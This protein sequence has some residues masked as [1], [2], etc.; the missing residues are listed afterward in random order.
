MNELQIPSKKWGFALVCPQCGFNYVHIRNAVV[1]AGGD[2][3]A[4]TPHG[5]M[6][7]PDEPAGRGTLV[8]LDFWCEGGHKFKINFQFHKGQV[9]VWSEYLGEAAEEYGEYEE[10]WRD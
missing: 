8:Q 9:F 7:F 10:L 5:T 6:R 2:V 3:T 1:N 4:V